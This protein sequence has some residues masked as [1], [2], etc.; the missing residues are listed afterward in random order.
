MKNLL[1]LLFTL[2][3]TVGVFA[4]EEE[5]KP[6]QTPLKL[7]MMYA[8]SHDNALAGVEVG[9]AQ[10]YIY[11]GFG[12]IN[13]TKPTE[14]GYK[15]RVYLKGGV[16]FNIADRVFL[17]PNFIYSYN[18]LTSSNILNVNNSYTSAGAGLNIMVR[19]SNIFHVI[20]GYDTFE[21]AS[22]GVAFTLIH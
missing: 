22:L 1:L 19:I 20:G 2:L 18:V 14:Y 5:D 9:F 4:Q 15:S 8:Y 12:G 7:A 17:I 3:L 6:Q 21:N 16:V 11:I 13:S 10:K